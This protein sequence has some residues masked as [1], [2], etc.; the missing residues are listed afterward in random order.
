M[1]TSRTTKVLQV[2]ASCLRSRGR[3]A[4][5]N[6]QARALL[7]ALL[8]DVDSRKA[9]WFRSKVHPKITQ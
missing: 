5:G 8:P 4:R 2:A 6:A 9:V 7:L 3:F 1:Q